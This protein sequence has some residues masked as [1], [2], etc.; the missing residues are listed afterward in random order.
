MENAVGMVEARTVAVWGMVDAS[1]L[2]IFFCTPSS[3]LVECT[4]LHSS[5]MAGYGMEIPCTLH[6]P[7]TVTVRT[8]HCPGFHPFVPNLQCSTD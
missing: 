1:P 6:L 7:Y 4:K 3:I 5:G 8:P 2:Q